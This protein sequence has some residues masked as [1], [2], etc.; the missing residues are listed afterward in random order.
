MFLSISSQQKSSHFHK[1][2]QNEPKD[3]TNSGELVLLM[4]TSA[5]LTQ[6]VTE[7]DNRLTSE[8]KTVTEL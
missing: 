2:L 1:K 3:E 4:M 7:D 5:V 6:E 8:I